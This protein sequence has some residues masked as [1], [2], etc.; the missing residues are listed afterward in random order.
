[1][2]LGLNAAGRHVC[3]AST[4]FGKL[5][6]NVFVVGCVFSHALLTNLTSSVDFHQSNSHICVFSIWPLHIFEFAAS[7]SMCRWLVLMMCVWEAA[8]KM[9]RALEIYREAKIG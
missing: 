9:C 8:V 6:L 2:P 3:L 4:A 1:M 7:Q 5:N